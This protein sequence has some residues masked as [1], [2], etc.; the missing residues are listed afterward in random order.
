MKRAALVAMI[1]LAACRGDADL[2][3]SNNDCAESA[4]TTATCQSGQCVQTPVARGTAVPTQTAGDCKVAACDGSG[5]TFDD[6]DDTDLPATTNPC[7]QATCTS[8]TPSLPPVGRGSACGTGL[9]CDGAGACVGCLD[10]SQCPGS[11]T[12]CQTRTCDAGMCG[13]SYAAPGTPVTA[14]TPGDCQVVECNGSGTTTSVAD[15]NDLPNDNNACTTDTCVGGVP[16]YDKVGAGV[17]C[18]TAQQCDGNGHCIADCGDGTVEG[19]ESCDGTDLNSKT[20]ADVGFTAGTLACKSDCTFDTSGCTTC[21][22]N[23]AE[24]G[25]A[26]DGTDLAGAT[27]QSRGFTTGTLA[28]K[29]NCT[30]DDSGCS[31]CG[32]G[33]VSGTELCDG[34]AFGATTCQSLGHAP[35]A[36]A[37]NATCD[38]IN[39]TACTGGWI[40]ANTSFS[41]TVCMDGLHYGSP[42]QAPWLAACTEDNGIWR[43]TVFDTSVPA[44]PLADPSWSNADGTTAGQMVTSLTGRALAVYNQNGKIAFLT[45]N[46]TGLNYF[47]TP[48]FAATPV[49]WQTGAMNQVSFAP[50]IYAVK[51]G[52][53]NNNYLAGWDPTSG[54]AIVLHGNTTATACAA[55]GGAGC[56]WPVLLGA[57]VTGTATSVVSG[58]DNINATTFDIHVAVTG[59]TPAGGA[60]TG[61]GIYWTCD[62]GATYTEDDTGVA[63]TD[64]PLLWKLVPDNSTYGAHTARTCPTNSASVGSY[65]STMYAAL[66]GGASIYKT[67]DGGATWAPANTGL[68]AGVAVYSIAI[69]CAQTIAAGGS[70]CPNPQLLYAGTA[71][72]V[73]KSVDGGGHWAIDGLQGS[74]VRAIGIEARHATWTIAAS[75]G[76]ATETGTTAT[77]TVNAHD[78]AVGDLVTIT[79]TT[80]PGYLGTF[81][82]TG[83]LSTTQFTVELPVS[84]LAASGGG[85]AFER[86][87]RVFGATDQPNAVFQTNTPH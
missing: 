51:L 44:L 48:S 13:F 69:D 47:G 37:C 55:N 19:T 16:T 83:V 22:N 72:G 21:G 77:I 12:D 57:G 42:L 1:A 41:G 8:G 78:F 5:G 71:A 64:K 6:V 3:S 35:G 34:A 70:T 23:T 74:T 56:S 62:N 75:P 20:C 29:N 45:T 46:T 17:S 18:G 2:C 7:V 31:T 10:A 60:A 28:C 85:S 52:S 33:I 49:V 14:Q 53:S 80:D 26:C 73:Y 38:A 30:F 9:Q 50:E 61:A 43:A 11:D 27:C 76:G 67:T 25:E 58:N 4:C 59:T 66:L 65:T 39:T 79:G 87:P 81:T 86:L 84:G 63:D 36:L 68:P 82:V 32:D 15:D 40:A 24:T 54:Q